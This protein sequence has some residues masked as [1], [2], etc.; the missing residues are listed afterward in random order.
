MTVITATGF[1]PDIMP[2]QWKLIR[3]LLSLNPAQMQPDL[4]ASKSRC[5]QEE[6]GHRSIPVRHICP[7]RRHRICPFPF[8]EQ[9]GKVLG[10]A[11]TAPSDL[12]H[13]LALT[14]DKSR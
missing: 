5:E 12:A 11:T 4:L 9:S 14:Y 7:I 3:P 6:L 8:R 10:L 2:A 13:H 1:V